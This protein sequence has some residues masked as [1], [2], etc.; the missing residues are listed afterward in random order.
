MDPPQRVLCLTLEIHKKKFKNLL[1]QNSLI[2]VLKIWYVALASDLV[3]S[4]PW[5]QNGP[6]PG[7]P[8]FEA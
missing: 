3:T 8:G 1:L 6:S 7:G 2:Q 4:G 5:V